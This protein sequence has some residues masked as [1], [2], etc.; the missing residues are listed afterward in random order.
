M[1]LILFE[2]VDEFISVVGR[3]VNSMYYFIS[4][5]INC[6]Y[7]SIKQRKKANFFLLIISY[8]SSSKPPSK[9]FFLSSL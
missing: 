1:V 9:F 2:R 3:K 5:L 8:C 7:Y 4:C 6:K